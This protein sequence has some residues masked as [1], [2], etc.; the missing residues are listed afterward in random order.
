MDRVIRPL[1]AMGATFR[2]R[3]GGFLPLEVTG[4]LLRALEHRSPVASAQVK[5][6]VLLAGLRATGRTAVTEP[7]RSR[8]HTER[9]LPAFGVPVEVAGERAA[10]TGPAVPRA[11]DVTIPGDPSS[12]AFLIVA[13]AIVPGSAV[14]MPE[15]C[16]NRTRTGAVEVLRRM[17]ACVDFED[18]RT[19]G[20][21][22]VATVT[23]RH[24]AGLSA[25]TIEPAEVPALI[26]EVP[27]LALVAT[28]A[29]GL[30]RF[31]GVGELRVKESDRLEA[32]VAALSAFGAH[33]RAGSDWIELRGPAT[34]RSA[35]VHA[36]GDH[37]LAMAWT[38]AGL[39]A[40]G[41]TVVDGFEA[42]GVSYPAFADDLRA[43]GA[44]IH[45]E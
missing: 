19:L 10:V 37:R 17:G 44:D 2:A 14:A 4:G 12:A 1:E 9:L 25:T 23:V 13:G 15:V 30:S 32:T 42:V 16:V 38:V 7:A 29:A 8:D 40:S 6:A 28:Q 35:R 11:T 24:T 45:E 18:E 22:P 34:L 36:V 33:V 21:E 31:E 5:S 41:T 43:L 27:L 26:D 20:A 39:A 3:D